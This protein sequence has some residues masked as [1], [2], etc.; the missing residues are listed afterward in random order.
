MARLTDQVTATWLLDTV[1]LVPNVTK[2][3]LGCMHRL[4]AGIR[5]GNAGFPLPPKIKRASSFHRNIL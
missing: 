1:A 3:N 5:K 4:L 2:P